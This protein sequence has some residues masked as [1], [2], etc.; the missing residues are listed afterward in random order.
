M[1]KDGAYFIG[2]RSFWDDGDFQTM[3][4]QAVYAMLWQ[5]HGTDIAGIR[6]RN[7]RL[8]SARLHIGLKK[9]QNILV[10][11]EKR[12][13]L[14][15]Y[16]SQIWIKAAIWHN[17]SKGKYSATQME[18]VRSRLMC[19]GISALVSEIMGYYRDRYAFTIPHTYPIDTPPIGRP[20]GSGSGTRTRDRTRSSR[21]RTR[22][23]S[24]SPEIFNQLL[25]YYNQRVTEIGKSTL[26]LLVLDGKPRVNLSAC[27]QQKPF[28]LEELKKAVDGCLSSKWR[29]ER[30]ERM[31]F[32]AIFKDAETVS[33]FIE[34]AKQPQVDDKGNDIEGE[35]DSGSSM[36]QE[37]FYAL[38]DEKDKQDKQD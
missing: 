38:I 3:E 30:P 1:A 9:F 26:R 13:K 7:D 6:Q 12:G 25:E 24:V 21:A 33:S 4:E 23:A 36:T 11:L 22:E 28:T 19:C 15:L 14:S 32:S 16:E 8:D 35:Y 2:D 10:I 18:A 37:E 27:L 17:L 34:A 20:S 5:S 29:R 31:M